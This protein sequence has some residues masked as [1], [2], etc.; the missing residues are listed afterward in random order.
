MLCFCFD[1]LAG[2]RIL[3]CLLND[4][5]LVLTEGVAA[6]N[7]RLAALVMGRKKGVWVQT[8]RKNERGAVVNRRRPDACEW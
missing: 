3:D 5:R 1:C 2:S 6:V 4:S 8:S 7:V